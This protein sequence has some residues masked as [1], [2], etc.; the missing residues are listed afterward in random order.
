LS[1]DILKNKL[2]QRLNAGEIVFGPFVRLNCPDVMEILGYSG[3]DFAIVD[4][5]HGAM[6]YHEAEDMV[7]AAVFAGIT[8]I[9]RVQENNATFILRALETGA[10]GIQIPQINDY[11]SALVASKSSRYFPLGDRGVCKF[12][13][14]S[15]YSFVPP[16]KYFAQ[17][18]EET[19]VIVH[20]EGVKGLQEL[21]RILEVDGIDVI[22]LGPFDLSQSLGITGQVNHPRVVEAMKDAIVKANK[23]KKIVGTFATNVKD[24]E[25]WA[26]CGV[27]YLSVYIDTGILGEAA[28]NVVSKLKQ[29]RSIQ[30]T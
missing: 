19:M 28:T 29:I 22:F 14:A 5:E 6:G 30:S 13:R 17:A 2:K 16:E 25:F 23:A 11:E 1:N 3:Y 21:D 26:N 12:S 15:K 27:K 20:I 7:R 4:L 8:P 18:N 9:I 10:Q 24:A